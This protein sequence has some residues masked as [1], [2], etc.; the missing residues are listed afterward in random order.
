MHVI[1]VPK[2]FQM[3]YLLIAELF[4]LAVTRTKALKNWDIFCT[5][6]I[7]LA[8]NWLCARRGR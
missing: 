7:Q 8:S 5:L 4:S 6:D 1:F 2:E 3:I